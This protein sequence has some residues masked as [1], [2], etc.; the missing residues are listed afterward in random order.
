MYR[1]IFGKGFGSYYINFFL[2]IVFMYAC[3]LFVANPEDSDI[4]FVIL[5]MNILLILRYYKFPALVILFSFILL[6]VHEAYYFFDMNLNIAYWSAYQTAELLNFSLLLNGVF[7]LCFSIIYGKGCIRFN[8][9][10]IKMDDYRVFYILVAMFSFSVV[11]GVQGSSIFD[12]SYGTGK[13]IKSTLFEY[14]IVFIFVA[15]FFTGSS[16]VRHCVVLVC[17]I[18]FSFKSLLF[19]SRIEVIQILIMYALVQFN[20]LRKMHFLFVYI[21]GCVGLLLIL[22]FG[23]LRYDPDY[24]QFMLDKG[25]GVLFEAKNIGD[26]KVSN[27]GDI[28]QASARMLGLARDGIWSDSVRIESFFSYITGPFNML[29]ELKNLHNLAAKDQYYFGAGGGGMFT[30]YFYVWLGFSGVILVSLFIPFALRIGLRV[31]SNS[32]AIVYATSLLFTF[33]RWFGYSPIGF[34]KFN[35]FCVV[36]FAGC[37][38]LHSRFVGNE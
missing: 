35:L 38:F 4:W 21:A 25:V 13:V 32:F 34:V 11:F 1:Y 29:T 15:M 8:I 33:P 31:N 12:A 7:F 23:E 3:I 2:S 19:G 9:D 37:V 16:L 24:I 22:L 6:Y 30:S 10:S 20:M 27:Q 5:M 36:V 28:L 14:G 17:I 26:I 18:F